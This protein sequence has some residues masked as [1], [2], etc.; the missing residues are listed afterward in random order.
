[1]LQ[2]VAA[3]LGF[4]VKAAVAR[5]A[6]QTGTHSF[7]GPNTKAKR[8]NVRANN[9]CQIDRLFRNKIEAFHERDMDLYRKALGM[10][11]TRRQT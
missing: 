11:L 9:V 4:G 1:M 10:R 3:P 5:F 6:Q 8:L 2:R 7:L